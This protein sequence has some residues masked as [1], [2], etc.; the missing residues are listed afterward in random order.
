MAFCSMLYE[1]GTPFSRRIA[2]LEETFDCVIEQQINVLYIYKYHTVNGYKVRMFPPF[3]FCRFDCEFGNME[4]NRLEKDLPEILRKC[5]A[6][7]MTFT[8]EVLMAL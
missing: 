6:I 2:L 5:C 8:C 7:R 3:E 1:P 4:L